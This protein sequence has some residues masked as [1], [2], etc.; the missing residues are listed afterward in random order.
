MANGVDPNALSSRSTLFVKVSTLVYGAE[1][2]KLQSIG[3][4]V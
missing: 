1:R 3:H 4:T 2:V